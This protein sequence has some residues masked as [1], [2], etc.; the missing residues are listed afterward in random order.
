MW[1]PEVGAL[2]RT[3]KVSESPESELTS[4]GECRP[5]SGAAGDS[6]RSSPRSNH[7]NTEDHRLDQMELVA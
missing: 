4:A 7:R 2:L 6:L 3:E 1:G 5:V